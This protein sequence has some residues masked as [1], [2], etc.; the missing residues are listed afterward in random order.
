[1]IPDEFGVGANSAGW[2]GVAGFLTLAKFLAFVALDVSVVWS[3]FFHSA[4][5]VEAV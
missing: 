4:A 5:S 3:G 2:G 1:M